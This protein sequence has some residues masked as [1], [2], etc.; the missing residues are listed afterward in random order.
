[1]DAHGR[2]NESKNENENKS[3][4]E[5]HSHKHR[6]KYYERFMVMFRLGIY[7]I[8]LQNNQSST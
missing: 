2:E 6:A 1:M 3:E 5:D 8:Y 7:Y 4:N